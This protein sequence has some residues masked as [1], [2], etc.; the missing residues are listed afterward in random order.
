MV[1]ALHKEIQIMKQLQHPN[2]VHLVDT[3][4]DKK[5]TVCISSNLGSHYRVM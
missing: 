4:G 3:F 2:I 5:Q 1:D